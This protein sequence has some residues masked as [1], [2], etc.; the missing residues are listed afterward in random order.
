MSGPLMSFAAGFACELAGRGYSPRAAAERLRVVARLSEW[1]EARDLAV[2]DLDPLVAGEFAAE[3]RAAGRWTGR[4]AVS[5]SPL[6][7]YLRAVGAVPEPATEVPGPAEV[8]LARYGTWLARERGLVP[9]TIERNTAAVR[10]FAEQLVSGGRVDFSALTAARVSAFVVERC[11]E[12]PA[13]V[14]RMA[15]ALRSFLVFAHADGLAGAGLGGAV[16]MTA[17]RRLARLPRALAGGQVAA[18]LASCDR[19]SAAGRRD[20]AVLTILSRL[21]LRAGEVAGLRLDDIDWLRGERSPCRAR[22]A[23]PTGCR[24]PPTPARRSWPTCPAPARLPAAGRCSCP[25]RRRCGR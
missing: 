9:A 25:S 5:L 18:L 1:L 3:R 15:T 7:E 23:G 22:G 24:C 16:P 14:Q 4:A 19:A 8:L 11:R 12:R 17:S 6:L 21:G 2:A 13:G 10:P 20:L